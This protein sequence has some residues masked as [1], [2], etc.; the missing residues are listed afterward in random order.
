MATGVALMLEMARS[1]TAHDKKDFETET[2]SL[3]FG[4]TRGIGSHRF[5]LLLEKHW[6][7]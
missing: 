4:T 5:F 7:A 2:L 6:D 1:P 3:L